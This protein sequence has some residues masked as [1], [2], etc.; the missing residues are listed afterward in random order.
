MDSKIHWWHK[1]STTKYL[2]RFITIREGHLGWVRIANWISEQVT[3]NLA[4]IKFLHFFK[5]TKKKNNIFSRKEPQKMNSSKREIQ[6]INNYQEQLRVQQFKLIPM[7]KFPFEKVASI[8]LQP[9]LSNLGAR[10]KRRNSL[11]LTSNK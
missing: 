8:P 3:H 10:R 7:R 5:K 6:A 2:N 11:F 9:G 1:I 4:K